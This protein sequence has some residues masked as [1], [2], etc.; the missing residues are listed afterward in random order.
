M[1]AVSLSQEVVK[2]PVRTIAIASNGL[3]HTT[4]VTPGT[5]RSPTFGGFRKVSG[6]CFEAA[7]LD[8]NEK[9]RAM[10]IKTVAVANIQRLE[11]RGRVGLL[12]NLICINQCT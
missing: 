3:K 2:K 6:R 11:V 1:S 4:E 8:V 7:M 12:V 5:I 9:S 10:P